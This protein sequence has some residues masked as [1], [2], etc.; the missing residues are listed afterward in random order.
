[1]KLRRLCTAPGYSEG[2]TWVNGQV[3]FCSDGLQRVGEDGH[4]ELWLDIQPAGTVLR[5]DGT[6]LICDNR[7]KALLQLSL[8]GELNVIADEY[9]GKPLNSLNDLTIDAAGN[10]YW[11][12][13]AGSSAK[14][15]VGRVFRV[16]PA[17]EVSVVADG[18]AFPNGV[19]VDPDSR[20]LYVIE[21]QSQK[22]LRYP[23]LAEGGGLGKVETFYNL[24]GN[25]GDGCA[26]DV[27]GNLWVADFHRPENGQGRITIM[28]SEGEWLGYLPVPAKV[29]SNIAFGGAEHNQIF[30]T[31]GTPPGVFTAQLKMKGFAGHPGKEMKV[32]RQ[33]PIAPESRASRVHPR[34]FGVPGGEAGTRGWYIWEKYDPATGLAEVRHE[35]RNE[36][37]TTRVLPW[38]STYRHLAYGAS[39]E[40][41]L[42][43]ERVNLF[44]SRD[45]DN[46][47][48]YL[49]HFQD[50]ICQMKGHNHF[51][52]VE[53]VTEDGTELTAR[54][55]AGDKPLNEDIATFRFAADCRFVREAEN[56]AKPQLQPGDK[57]YLTWCR[58]KDQRVVHLL[59]DAASLPVLK[60]E[61]EQQIAEQVRRQGLSGWVEAVDGREIRLLI[62][63]RHWAQANPLKAGQSV[64]LRA[65]GVAKSAD[66]TEPAL[67]QVTAELVSRKNLGRYGS[68]A[69]VAVLRTSNVET[70][71]QVASWPAQQIV[72]LLVSEQQD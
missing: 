43:G 39:P 24:G 1:M 26:F 32:V 36:L 12:D 63:G 65:P 70:A 69:T 17:G 11:T 33:L 71:A 19:E 16:T 40:D 23:L 47:R 48:A 66:E 37:Y 56:V 8:D 7:H 29:V 14:K 42:P 62:F 46:P 64:T 34:R 31:T 3:F 49:T 61:Q 53:S 20:F 10:I 38:V 60:Q 35:G 72:Q 13:P 52:Q 21:S 30:C 51:W 57:V 67:Q 28:D 2:P 27:D 55:M 50:E 4:P 44:F 6:L 9:D 22:I 41:L 54:V 58:E 5:G 68:G 18:L 59:A 15:P 45:R 25:G